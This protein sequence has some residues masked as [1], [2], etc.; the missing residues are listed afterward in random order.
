[1]RFIDCLRSLDAAFAHRVRAALTLLGLIVGS[2]SIVLLAS[3][4]RG[5]EE[6]LVHT[7]QEASNDD[8]A[9]AYGDEPPPEQRDRT[10]R[11]LSR[12]DAAAVASARTGDL[13][14]AE[15]SRDV[16]AR[17][18]GRKKRVA[19]VSS[20]RSTMEL[21]RLQVERGRALDDEDRRRGSRVSVI[22]AEVYE[23][24]VRP[25]EHGAAPALA[26][27]RIEVDGHLFSVVGVLAR[28]PSLD[29]T[30]STYLWDRK[31]LIPETTYDALYAPG[32]AIDRIYVRSDASGHDASRGALRGVVL[33]RHFGVANFTLAKD[34]SGGMETLV[35]N[36][37]RV[38]LL[39]TGGLSLLA[40]GINIMNVL[41]V[42]VAERTREIGLRRAVGASRRSILVQFL[43]ESVALSFGGGAAGVAV[44]VLLACAVA[45]GARAALGHWELAIVPWSLALGLALAAMTGLVFGLLPAWRAAKLAPI[46]ALRSE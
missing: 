40:S 14:A 17:Y 41:L 20:G 6:Y 23:E 44:G 18:A 45:A 43:L 15:S 39:G 38:L 10:T 19:F 2:A 26:G 1:M 8:V 34:E 22:G 32:H 24:L 4:L 16:F 28:K 36:V 11:G 30:D 25:G 33:R 27:L 31:V 29:H 21:Y 5:G 35:L 7:N 12:A 3:L 42:T 9:E 37:I 13:V 46:D